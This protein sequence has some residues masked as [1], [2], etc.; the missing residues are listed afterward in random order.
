ML[1]VVPLVVH[2]FLGQQGPR[3]HAPCWKKKKLSIFFQSFLM[4]WP[5][6]S[7]QLDLRRKKKNSPYFYAQRL[8]LLLVSLCQVSGTL[9]DDIITYI[10]NEEK[11]KSRR[12]NRVVEVEGEK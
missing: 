1:H 5:H 2:L 10:G 3:R 6:H 11:K 9:H 12:L 7:S 4:S 8:S